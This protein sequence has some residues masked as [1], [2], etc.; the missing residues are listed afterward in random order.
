MNVQVLIS[1]MY[2]S[3]KSLLEKMNVQTSAIVINQCERNEIE[4][5]EFRGHEILWISCEERGV[6]LSRNTALLRAT[7]DVLLI[8]D[9]DVRYIDGYEEIVLD[10]FRKNKKAGFI[11]FNVDCLNEGRNEIVVKKNQRVR[12]YNSLKFGA[13]RF[14]VK[15]DVL[16][17]K[18]IY[19]SLLYGGGCIYSAG[20]DN[21]FI[22]DCLKKGIYVLASKACIGTVTHNESTWFEGYNQKYFI[23]LGHLLYDLFT[24]KSGL[25]AFL[26]ILKNRKNYNG[27]KVKEILKW[28]KI[29]RKEEKTIRRS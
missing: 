1:T 4:R 3:D 20:E 28:I 21:I 11:A 14:A 9:D 17:H 19:F 24:W 6:G 26:L 29:G 18:R 10:E 23:D 8:A 15:K 2:Q 27:L 22:N 16:F 5:F 13:Y 12:F 25:L 7:G